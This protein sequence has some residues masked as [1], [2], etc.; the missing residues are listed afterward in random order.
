MQHNADGAAAGLPEARL[1][2]GHRQLLLQTA[3][4]QG[5]LPTHACWA[6]PRSAPCLKIT[7]DSWAC[8]VCCAWQTHENPA[9][10]SCQTAGSL[11]E[12]KAHLSPSSYSTLHHWL[13]ALYA[14]TV[15]CSQLQTSLGRLDIPALEAAAWALSLP[16]QHSD[17]SQHAC[18]LAFHDFRKLLTLN[19][20]S[21]KCLRTRCPS[22]AWGSEA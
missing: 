17:A 10:S 9:T 11:L 4:N 1:Q 21:S 20:P 2:K 6:V 5:Q 3:T 8:P 22:S 7:L 18:K 15:P 19:Q 12:R 16:A 13:P 14:A